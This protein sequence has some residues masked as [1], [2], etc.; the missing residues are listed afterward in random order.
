M[1]EYDEQLKQ[2][3][4]LMSVELNKMDFHDHVMILVDERIRAL[5]EIVETRLDADDK[6]LVL[7]N[8][9]YLRRLLDLNHSHEKQVQDRSEFVKQQVYMTDRENLE[10]WRD[11]V[12]VFMATTQGRGSAYSVMAGTII[13]LVGIAAGVITAFF[14]R[15]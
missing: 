3:G 5:R 8:T 14:A 11:L 9:E 1:T 12:N 10:K 2:M 7:Q 15:H 13:A 4:F 6:A